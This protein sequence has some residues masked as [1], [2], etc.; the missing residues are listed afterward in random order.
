MPKSAKIN[1]KN[2]VIPFATI[3]FDESLCFNSQVELSGLGVKISQKQISRADFQVNDL[4]NPYLIPINKDKNKKNKNSLRLPFKSVKEF[5]ISKFWTTQYFKGERYVGTGLSHSIPLVERLVKEYKEGALARYRKQIK[6]LFYTLFDRINS[7]GIQAIIGLGLIGFFMIIILCNNES[8]LTI[9]HSL[10]G[11]KR[12]QRVR[13]ESQR[14]VNWTNLASRLAV[15]LFT[16]AFTFMQIVFTIKKSNVSLLN[17]LINST[18]NLYIVR[19]T[20]KTIEQYYMFE[21]IVFLPF[22]LSFLIV[23]KFSSK[24]GRFNKF[25]ANRFADYFQTDFYKAIQERKKQKFK[26]SL[27]KKQ[28]KML[29]S[30]CGKCKYISHKCC[31]HYLCSF[32]CCLCCC[33]CCVPPGSDTRCFLYYSLRLGWQQTSWNKVCH[34]LLVV[35]KWIFL[36]PLW[37]CLWN[38]SNKNGSAASPAQKHNSD[39]AKNGETDENESISSDDVIDQDDFDAY[40]QTIHRF[41][42]PCPF[43]STPFSTSNRAQSAAV[44]AIY[45]YDVLN[46][47]MYVYTLSLTPKM[48]PFL[49]NIGTPGIILDLVIQIMQVIVVGVKFYPILVVADSDP[50]WFIH[51]CSSFYMFIIWISWLFRKAFCSRSEAFVRQAFRVITNQFAEQINLAINLQKNLTDLIFAFVTD[52]DDASESYMNAVKSKVPQL[53]DQYFG[54]QAN[55]S[56]DDYDSNLKYYSKA[57]NNLMTTQSSTR[58][59][60][61]NQSLAKIHQ[62]TDT[63]STNVSNSKS[64]NLVE[65][66]EIFP[67][68]FLLS[69]L[70]ACHFVKFLSHFYK[71]L[72][73]WCRPK[74]QSHIYSNGDMCQSAFK[75]LKTSREKKTLNH[76]VRYIN[77][78]FRDTITFENLKLNKLSKKYPSKIVQRYEVSFVW[79]LIESK[80]YKNIHCFRYSKQFVNTYTVAFMVIYFFCLFGLQLS[81]VLGQKFVHSIEKLYVLYLKGFAPRLDARQHNLTTEIN[82]CII[83]ASVFMSFQLLL[84]IKTYRKD[85]LRL[86]RG[87]KFFRSL[88]LKYKDEDYKT[89]IRKRNRTSADITAESLHFPGFLIA[90]LVYGYII[91]VFILLGAMSTF[92]R[93]LV[94]WVLLKS[95]R[96][97][98]VNI[99]PYF[100]ISYFN[101][102]FDCFLGL[103]A[104][105]SRVWK[106]TLF[107]VIYLPRLDKS[108]FDRKNEFLIRNIDKGHLAYINQVRMEHWYNNNVLNGFCEI[109]IESMF[110]SQYYEENFKKKSLIN[111]T[112]NKKVRL[113]ENKKM[114]FLSNI[115]M[116]I[117]TRCALRVKEILN[118]QKLKDYSAIQ[119]F[120][121]SLFVQL[122]GFPK[123]EMRPRPHSIPSLFEQNY[124]GNYLKI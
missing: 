110:F 40:D 25:I 97:R 35:L 76:N 96:Q 45:T 17:N 23:L 60:L 112:R 71:S 68:Y 75:Q 10:F 118:F 61:R 95:D 2:K 46:I 3:K 101:F 15:I 47:F 108:M 69:Y 19:Q 1:I 84:S 64:F 55:K 14:S 80:I 82:I 78:F 6:K 21:D 29:K 113:D 56:F 32:F 86:H 22:S 77:N 87:E 5:S 107:S 63:I 49:G 48:I 81:N 12:R 122:T 109:L 39:G 83:I 89:I 13:I 50:G 67:L 30:K 66:L 124:T 120:R 70:V 52:Q 42:A 117:F 8:F 90:H 106:T 116:P 31:S 37:K 38:L 16:S 53:F 11:K 33:S 28:S 51:L 79:G 103:F 114:R 98:I 93:F 119:L 111:L 100:L 102:F 94:R 74:I 43:P 62:L 121:I 44:Y 36:I 4:I 105:I 27:S 54:K 57:N 58:V 91:L 104:C 9:W 65:L 88:V 34:I 26:E 59:G 7:K 20:C 123:P 73:N 72:L 99:A 24:I 41:K 92:L 18:H 115:D 85:V